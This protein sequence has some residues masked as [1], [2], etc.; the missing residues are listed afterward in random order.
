MVN[1]YRLTHDT[2]QGERSTFVSLYKVLWQVSILYFMVKLKTCFKM[3]TCKTVITIVI[4]IPFSPDV[5]IKEPKVEQSFF[6]QAAHL[7]W[8][9]PI[10]CPQ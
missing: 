8:S 5:V 4:C 10:S 7:F 2:Q 1:Q 6:D 9:N 3:S